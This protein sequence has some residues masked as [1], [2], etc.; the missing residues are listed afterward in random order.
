MHAK[1]NNRIV[2]A[3]DKVIISTESMACTTRTEPREPALRYQTP[4]S[5]DI[6]GMD[7]LEKFT[8]PRFTLYDGKSNPQSYVRQ[9]CKIFPSNLGDLRLK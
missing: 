6:E 7:L 5:R 3:S 8:T 9:M 2:L 1:L 4:F